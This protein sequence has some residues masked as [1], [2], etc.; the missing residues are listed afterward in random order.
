MSDL[1]IAIFNSETNSFRFVDPKAKT[2]LGKTEIVLGTNRT[3]D[4]KYN[5]KL[6]HACNKQGVFEF[7]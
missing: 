7:T 4:R 2:K 5:L 6:C 1:K 3:L